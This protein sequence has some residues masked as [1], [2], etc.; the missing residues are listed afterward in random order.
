MEKTMGVKNPKVGLVNVGTEE[1]KG[2]DLAKGTYELLK[3]ENL[4]TLISYYGNGLTAQ[5]DTTRIELLRLLNTEEKTGK[6]IYEF[7]RYLKSVCAVNNALFQ[8]DE[9]AIN[10]LI[11]IGQENLVYN[12][13]NNLYL[14]AAKWKK[15]YD[16]WMDIC[17]EDVKTGEQVGLS[18]D[19]YE[20]CLMKVDGS[21]KKIVKV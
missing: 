21:C 20:I 6:R 9:R 12:K 10:F 15:V 4:L 7:T 19:P 2:N 17:Y 5:A 13:D 3:G 18:V 14:D 11:E 16:K 8:L 1:E